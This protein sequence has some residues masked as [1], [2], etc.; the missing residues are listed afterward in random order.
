MLKTLELDIHKL[1]F[2][3][4]GAD[5]FIWP[6]SY[7]ERE[8]FHREIF[9]NATEYIR[10]F[11]DENSIPYKLALKFFL[12]ES[13]SVFW[14]DAL[15]QSFKKNNIS[16]I[17]PETW[18]YW[19]FLF[20]DKAPQNMVSV[21]TLMRRPKKPQLQKRVKT[22]SNKIKKA[23]KIL[24]VK[25]GG[26]NFDGLKIKPFSRSVV[27]N[28]II[29]TQRTHT[30]CSQAQ[31]EKKDVVYIRSDRW[32]Y[33]LKDEELVKSI[34]ELNPEVISTL[35][36]II[37]S[38]YQNAGIAY[39]EHSRKYLQQYLEK[40]T[41]AISV[42]YQRL[43]KNPQNL[44]K[45][46]WTGTAGNI[47]DFMLRVAVKKTGGYVAGHDHGAGLG[48]VNNPM[49]GFSE[50]FCCDEFVTFN[51]NQANEIGKADKIWLLSND[52]IPKLK[53]LDRTQGKDSLQIFPHLKDKPTKDTKHIFL[54]TELY[55]RDRGRPGPN[56]PDLLQ[57]DWQA[58][59]IPKLKEWGYD[60]TM[61][62]HPESP[63]PPPAIFESN[64][65]AKIISERMEDVL[66]MA[67]L[68]IFD[69]V[70]STSLRVAIE[71]NIPFV[72]IDFYNHPWTEKGKELIQKRCSF[73]EGGFN[74]IGQRSA[75]W[76]AVKE[77]IEQAPEKANNHEFYNYFYA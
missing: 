35:M 22:L 71:T 65:G 50:F 18:Q 43:H 23:F 48:H 77:G 25:E 15:K 64:L 17:V 53:G 68:I 33:T 29:A 63:F 54:M 9:T 11:E 24:N 57:A 6:F 72:L 47:W 2:D 3:E 58:R 45:H 74:E 52:E 55:D 40:M 73:V 26:V 69:C 75:D 67:D 70:Y 20:R 10:K 49:I 34:K 39:P 46:L 42:H 38:A 76:N 4:N 13:I 61:K 51:Q 62:L 37:E 56:C 5:G 41:A 36:S 21:E 30:I 7:P 32:F 16:P 60:I 31:Q 28:D 19:P 66:E 12:T 8:K 14:G 27:V 1:H 59:I 44:P